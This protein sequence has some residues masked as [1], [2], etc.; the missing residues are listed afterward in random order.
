MLSY[1]F[2]NQ[3]PFW[4]LATEQHSSSVA[5]FLM[6][7]DSL[8]KTKKTIKEA[9]NFAVILADLVGGNIWI[10]NILRGGKKCQSK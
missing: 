2:Y 6:G 8:K 10:Q 5:F 1:C 7:G 9:V 3:F 4:E